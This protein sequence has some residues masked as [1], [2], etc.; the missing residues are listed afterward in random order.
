LNLKLKNQNDKIDN[1]LE[2]IEANQVFIID[3]ELGVGIDNC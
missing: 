1:N 2:I 3:N